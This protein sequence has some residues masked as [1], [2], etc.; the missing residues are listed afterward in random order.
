M[1]AQEKALREQIAAEIKA[2]QLA[3]RLKRQAE[4]QPGACDEDGWECHASGAF[5]GFE[6]AHRIALGDAS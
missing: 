1:S 4:A 5:M 3:D 6:A 2:A